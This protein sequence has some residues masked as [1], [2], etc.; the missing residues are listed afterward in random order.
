MQSCSNEIIEDAPTAVDKAHDIS[1]IEKHDL[2]V[3][4]SSSVTSDSG[5][6]P[7]YDWSSR[8]IVNVHYMF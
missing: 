2:F 3:E 7:P 4:P 6:P 8:R 5:T 1:K